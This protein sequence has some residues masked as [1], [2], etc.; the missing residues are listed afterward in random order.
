M[1][2]LGYFS[3]LYKE[4]YLCANLRNTQFR[5]HNI[6]P[7]YHQLLDTCFCHL[8]SNTCY[9]YSQKICYPSASKLAE[10]RLQS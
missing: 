4:I 10:N 3:K 5:N 1:P 9:E 8:Y 7:G 6:V 2:F